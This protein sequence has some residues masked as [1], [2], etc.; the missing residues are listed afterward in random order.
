MPTSYG[1]GTALQFTD[2]SQRQVLELGEKIHYYN[3]NVTPIFSLFGMKS[4]LTPVPIFEWME[5]EYMIKKSVKISMAG[6]SAG[7]D[8]ATTLLSDTATSGVNGENVIINFKKQAEVEAFEVGGIYSGTFTG[9]ATFS[10]DITHLICIAIGKEVNLTS[11]SD[12]SVQFV[13]AHAHSS[14]NAYNTEAVAGGTDVIGFN[15]DSTLT[16]QYVATAG[17]LYDNGTAVSYY[18]YQ[19]HSGSKGFGEINFADADYFMIGGGPGQYAEGAAVGVE[20]R[21]KVRRLKNCTQIFREPYTVTGTAK[22]AKHYGGSEMSRL[23]A[24]K[25]AKIKGDIEWA[26]LTNGAISLDASS[27]NPKR[28]FQGLGVGGTA[29]SISSLNA[30][31]N[32]NCQWDESEGL[33]NLDGVVEYVFSD[34]VSGSMTK[35]VF[36][37]NKWMVKLAAATRSADT[38]FY[39]TGEK[40]TSGLRVRSYMGPVGQLDFVAHPYLKGAYEDYAVAIDPANFSVRPLAGRDMQLRKDIVKD[41]RDG[42]TDEWLMEVGVEVRNEQTHAILKLV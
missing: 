2:A 8:S 27:E 24:R 33:N 30:D 29:G 23:Q 35:T 1:T 19:T 6:E 16:L 13:G 4:S 22:A 36:A 18:G 11:P 31:A 12:K 42:Q 10:T 5:D 39:D 17:Q 28:T 41:G 21:K 37:S 40:T 32:A 25:L 38:G 14:L 34:M 3:P 15:T 9:S 20:S 26:L 7:A